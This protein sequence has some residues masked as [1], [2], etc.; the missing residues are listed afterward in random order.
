LDPLANIETS[1][2]PSF[3]AERVLGVIDH[4]LGDGMIEV[5]RPISAIECASRRNQSSDFVH[6]HVPKESVGC[7]SGNV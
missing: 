6:N 1:E 4:P 5:N 3:L 7:A 2:A